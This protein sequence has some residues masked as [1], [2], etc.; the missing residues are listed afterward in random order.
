MVVRDL[1]RLP[2]RKVTMD[3][4][5]GRSDAVGRAHE[6]IPLVEESKGCLLI[7]LRPDD[8]WEWRTF[9]MTHAD[10][11]YYL[12]YIKNAVLKEDNQCQ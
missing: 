2:K 6:I 11:I 5:I 1:S 7:V 10:I 3:E 8:T 12:S 4:L 9:G